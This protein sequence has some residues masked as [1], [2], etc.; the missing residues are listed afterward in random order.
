MILTSLRPLAHWQNHD[1]R[2]SCPGIE[3]TTH[4]PSIT[5]GA[6][7][8]G[9]WHRPTRR[10]AVYLVEF[11]TCTDSKRDHAADGPG[12]ED[13]RNLPDSASSREK[14]GLVTGTS[15]NLKVRY[16]TRPKSEAVIAALNQGASGI[17]IRDR[18]IRFTP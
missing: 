14:P 16:V 12:A 18:H 1:G 10:A 2:V 4:D 11:A 17:K 13:S 8:P 9:H 6:Q 3:A 5:P 7:A 15:C